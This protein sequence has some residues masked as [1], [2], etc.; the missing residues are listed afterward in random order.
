MTCTNEKMKKNCSFQIKRKLGIRVVCD[1]TVD[2]SS[3]IRALSLAV[4][5]KFSS[6]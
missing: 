5:S 3:A 1:T 2:L 4:S 6:H